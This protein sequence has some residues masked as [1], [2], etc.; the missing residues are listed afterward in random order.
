MVEVELKIAKEMSLKGFISL[1]EIFMK[2]L[3]MLV[4]TQYMK[5]FGAALEYLYKNNLISGKDDIVI[6]IDRFL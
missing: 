1:L 4:N 5:N 6:C 3:I 2:I